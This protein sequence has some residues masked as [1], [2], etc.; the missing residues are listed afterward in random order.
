MTRSDPTEAAPNR[1]EPDGNLGNWIRAPVFPIT[2]GRCRR[3]DDRVRFGGAEQGRTEANRTQGVP[4]LSLTHSNQRPGALALVV[5]MSVWFSG[6][7]VAQ[8]PFPVPGGGVDDGSGAGPGVQVLTRGP[9]HEAFA[10]PVVYDPRPGPVVPKPPPAPIEEL[11]PDQRPQGANVV[12]VPGYWCWDD[13]RADFLWVSGIWRD[14]PPGRNWVPGYWSQVA[15][16]FQWAPGFWAAVNPGQDQNQI[17]YLPP[18]PPSLE[19]GPN[20][21]PPTPDATWI[22]GTWIWQAT[23]YVWRPGFW[24]PFQN[25]WLWVPAHYNWTPN[26]YVF[27]NGYWDRPL[28][29]RGTLFAPV[30][31]QQPVYQQPGYSYTPTIALAATGLLTS[32]FVRPSYHQYYFG[33]YYGANSVQSGIYPWY[34]YHQSRYGYDPLFAHA[35]IT[36]T[37]TDPGWINHV[38]EEYRYRN[39]HPEARPPQ[40]YALQQ[41]FLRRENIN[42]TNINEVR[43]NTRI[44]SQALGRPLTQMASNPN[45]ALRFEAIERQQRGEI[46]RQSAQLQAFREQRARQESAGVRTGAGRPEPRLSEPRRVEMPHSPIM[47][48]PNTEARFAPPAAPVHPRVEPSVAIPHPNAPPVERREPHFEQVPP[49]LHRQFRPEPAPARREELRREEL[50]REERKPR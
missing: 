50:R 44:Q 7:A 27:V 14:I 29:Q 17:E 42:I 35:A 2:L 11:P 25:D 9:I 5:G 48:R 36:N 16:G 31:F 41:T 12:W 20:V 45:A 34:S 30:Y 33:D 38:H 22:P 28:Q 49:E 1:N 19:T 15:E 43:P 10:E 3:H 37:R 23:R 6:A 26:G 32:L 46:A 13:G 18:P 8:Q 24:A 47:G 4:T 21:P 39:D 40:T